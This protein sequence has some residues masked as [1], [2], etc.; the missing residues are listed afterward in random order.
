[1]KELILKLLKELE[2]MKTNLRQQIYLIVKDHYCCTKYAVLTDTSSARR[3]IVQLGDG[4]PGHG[5]LNVPD[6]Y[7]TPLHARHS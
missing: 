2:L 5:R 3:R 7:I 4:R 6:A 1:M